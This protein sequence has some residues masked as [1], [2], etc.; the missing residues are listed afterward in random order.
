MQRVV[1]KT[2][3]ISSHKLVSMEGSSSMKV[4]FELVDNDGKPYANTT[5]TNIKID[6]N[7]TLDVA[8]FCNVV[9]KQLGTILAGILPQQLLAYSNKDA[10]NN[11]GRESP[12]EGNES[13]NDHGSTKNDA[14]IVLI[15][16][17]TDDTKSIRQKIY[18]TAKWLS[19][20]RN[21][22]V[23][24][25]DLPLLGD[26]TGFISSELP[27]KIGVHQDTL[28]AWMIL[29]GIIPKEVIA[30]LFNPV[31]SEPCAD[32]LSQVVNRIVKPV[33]TGASEAS[34]VSFWDDMIRHVL[35]YVLQDVGQ[36][37]RNS[38]HSASTGSKRPDFLFLVNSVCVF[39]GEE[40]A[41]GY[42]IA[43]PRSEL[44]EKM[45]W[46]YGDVPY[47]LGYTAVGF[48]VRLYAIIHTCDNNIDSRELVKGKL[49][50]AMQGSAQCEIVSFD[51]I[52]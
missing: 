52:D 23:A 32:F 24:P 39:R 16:P 34:F 46:T 6:K 45:E 2:P 40:K 36:S 8:D 33:D 20:F 44:I 28:E 1:N 48:E 51:Y 35:S 30:K 25:Y 10:F 47:L 50:N 7:E 43:T 26:L 38:S 49:T 17:L 15:L 42:D 14:I 11:R 21:S 27:V 9:C 41:P 4:W 19:E 18:D 29:M 37:E 5:T 12:M 22:Q 13:I 31:N 3:S